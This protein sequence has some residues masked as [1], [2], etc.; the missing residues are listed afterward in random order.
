MFNLKNTMYNTDCPKCWVISFL[1][2]SFS[3]WLFNNC[4]SIIESYL[5]P[6][7]STYAALFFHTLSVKD[8][9]I[10]KGYNRV[11]PHNRDLL[12]IIFGSLLGKGNAEKKKDGTRII[13]YQEA[14]HVKYLLLLHNQLAV[15][16]Y[17]NPTVPKINTKLGKNS[18]L[19]RTIRF[20]T[21]NYTSFDWIYDLWYVNGIKVVPQSIGDY[22]TPLALAIWVMDSSVKSSGGLLFTSC[23]SYSDCLL[24]VQVLDKNFGLKSRIRPTGASSQ[25]NVYIPKEYVIDLRNKVSAFIFPIMKYKLFP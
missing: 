6:F 5:M 20:A 24:I 8:K 25:H 18:K 17:C 21:W 10:I 4:Q 19:H 11:G 1:N 16:G 13:F 15:V 12:S 22:F 14:V 2:I 7:D 23:F 9:K 3:V